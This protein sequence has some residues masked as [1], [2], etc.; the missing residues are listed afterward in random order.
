M[1]KDTTRLYLLHDCYIP[2]PEAILNIILVSD[3]KL[4]IFNF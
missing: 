1:D 2:L 3:F 4:A